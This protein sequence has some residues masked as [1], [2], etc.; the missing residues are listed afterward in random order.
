MDEDQSADFAHNLTIQ[1]YKA[2]DER[3]KI[4][5]SKTSSPV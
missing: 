5:T 2:G 3:K 1:R 4:K